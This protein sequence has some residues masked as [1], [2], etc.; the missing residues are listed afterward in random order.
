[1]QHSVKYIGQE[2]ERFSLLRKDEQPFHALTFFEFALA[3]SRKYCLIPNG[4]DLLVS[5]WYSGDLIE[6]YRLSLL[7]NAIIKTN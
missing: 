2:H 7:Y 5:T 1:M 6:G 3:N 4:D